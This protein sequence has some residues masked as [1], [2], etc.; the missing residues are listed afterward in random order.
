MEKMRTLTR[1]SP[2]Q[3]QQSEEAMIDHSRLALVGAIGGTY[4]SL[5][6]SDIDELTVHDFALLN[7]AD[8]ASPMQAIER[9]LKTIPRTPNK[10]GLS[11]AGDV[12]GDKVTMS[13]LPWTFTR[14]DIRAATGA[15]IVSLVN[16]FDALALAL[17]HLSRYELTGVADGAPALYG[18]KLAIGAGTGFGAAALTWSGEAWIPVSGPSRL[19]PVPLPRD[20]GFEEVLSR[21][22]IASAETVLSGRGLVALYGV[23]CARSGQAA[24]LHGAPEITAA[25][26]AH[27]DTA[28]TEALELLTVWLGQLAG[29]LALIFGA[30]GGVYLGGGLCSN[31]VPLLSTPR[32][33]DAFEGQGE[34]RGYLGEV[35]VHVIKT[36]ADANMRG[37]A[38]A[39]ARCLP[40]HTNARRSR[41]RA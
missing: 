31:I 17:P 34:R 8:F 15:E 11:V 1:G 23:L 12:V 3:L 27:E 26:L 10:V 38:V 16:E 39:L 7:S 6:V 4:I 25:G 19:L 9:Y 37:A 24:T 22:G 14:N 36:G 41:V 29:D 21:D 28:A 32:F 33:K 35:A 40:A 13:H 2:P 18:T 20:L 5:A 30:R